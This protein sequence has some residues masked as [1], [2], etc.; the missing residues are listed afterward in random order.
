MKL[1]DKQRFE[2]DGVAWEFRKGQMPQGTLHAVTRNGSTLAVIRSK[3][4]GRPIWAEDNAVLHTRNGPSNGW[5]EHKPENLRD[6][7]RKGSDHANAFNRDRE[8]AAM[9]K[10]LKERDQS[11][12]AA[13]TPHSEKVPKKFKSIGQ[14]MDWQKKQREQGKTTDPATARKE[15]D[16]GM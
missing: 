7:V 12:V 3:D 4:M 6:A 8:I 5:Q 15:Q 11:K 10:A 9:E 14:F 2:V 1:H 13:N 16:M